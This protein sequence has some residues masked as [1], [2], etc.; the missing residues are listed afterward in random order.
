MLIVQR[1]EDARTFAG[2]TVSVS[3][4]AR[5][6]SGTPSI[7]IEMAQQFGT[8]GSSTVFGIG[9]QKTAI[10]TDWERYSFTVSVPSI[11]GKTIGSGSNLALYIWLSGGSDFDSRTDTLGIQSNTFDIWGVQ[12]EAGSTA[13][14]FRRNANSLQGELAAC[15]RYYWRTSGDNRVMSGFAISTTSGM[16]IINNPVPLR[17]IPT[18][19]D[20]SGMNWFDGIGG[21]SFT[22][23]TLVFPGI[24]S[25]QVTF[26]GAS[27]LTTRQPLGFTTNGPT[28]FIGFSAEL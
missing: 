9:S 15:Q 17:S 1:I 19:L 16:V 3:F 7:A 12:L 24:N 18:S 28:D 10:T 8:G 21:G 20:R 13:T 26:T 23:A 22:A 27:G 4:F 2:Q 14:P 6:N 25:S 11:S 5:A